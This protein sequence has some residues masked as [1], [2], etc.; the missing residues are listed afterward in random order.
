MPIPQ[1]Y[2]VRSI[3][4]RWWQKISFAASERNLLLVLLPLHQNLVLL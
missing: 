4:F 1:G 2:V 3:F